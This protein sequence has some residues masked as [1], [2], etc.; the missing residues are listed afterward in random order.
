MNAN[1]KKRRTLEP[2]A[3]PHIVSMSHTSKVVVYITAKFLFNTYTRKSPDTPPTGICMCQTLLLRTPTSMCLAIPD[4]RITQRELH[5]VCIPV[6]WIHNTFGY[7]LFGGSGYHQFLDSLQDIQ[8]TDDCL[9]VFT[10]NEEH[11]RKYTHPKTNISTL[12]S[13]FLMVDYSV[14]RELAEHACT[15]SIAVDSALFE[16]GTCLC[17]ES[18]DIPAHR[19]HV[20]NLVSM[21]KAKLL[22]LSDFFTPC[23]SQRK[24]T[25]ECIQS[26]D[27]YKI[28]YLTPPTIPQKKEL[29]PLPFHIYPVKVQDTSPDPSTLKQ[30]DKFQWRFPLTFK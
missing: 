10:Y 17:R 18:L 2:G 25:Y 20:S 6:R 3:N 7:S 15:E 16:Q 22:H 13:D 21:K 19:L 26:Y 28:L 27:M 11:I 30:P 1:G 4:K 14:F 29:P 9:N 8:K 5:V 24:Y 12:Q 23:R